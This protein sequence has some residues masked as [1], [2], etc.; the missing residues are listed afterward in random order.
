MNMS[1]EERLLQEYT[2]FLTEVDILYSMQDL[3]SLPNNL[4]DLVFGKVEEEVG[5]RKLA[6]VRLVS[7]AWKA[8]FT[9]YPGKHRAYFARHWELKRLTKIMPNLR[10]L[11]IYGKAAGKKLQPLS[12]CLQLTYLSLGYSPHRRSCPPKGFP[13][14]FSH[15]PSSLKA[16]ELM[17]ISA[18]PAR[19]ENLKLAGL[20]SL[21]LLGGKWCTEAISE[22][23]A[24]LTGLQVSL[25]HTLDIDICQDFC[26]MTEPFSCRLIIILTI[27]VFY[28]GY[29]KTS[30]SLEA[31]YCLDVRTA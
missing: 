3:T 20:T 17:H 26:R 9:S 11:T 5:L 14:N 4:V 23:L 24:H 30:C 25:M 15:L 6:A 2:D 21:R 12:S 19:F 27:R 31:V 13:L 18:Y 1:F 8:A 29:T 10:S 16:I 28:L 22:L 7:K